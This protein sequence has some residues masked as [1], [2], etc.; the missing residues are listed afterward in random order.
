[1]MFAL[2]MLVVIT[3]AQ[4]IDKKSSVVNFKIKAMGMMNVEGTF[5][6]FS[7]DVKFDSKNLSSSSI[8]VCI[9]ASSVN[10][11]NTQRDNH[12]R[13][14]DFIDSEK[15][16][17]ICFTSSSIKADGNNYIAEGKLTLH[18]VTKT[19]KIP[20]TYQNNTLKGTL[21]VK[22]LD[23]KV[24]ESYGTFRAG[25]IIYLDINCVLNSQ[26]LTRL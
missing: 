21:E 17:K 13:S 4:T 25:E 26:N 15:Y 18:G 9:N 11:G 16:G 2:T 12:I 8:D 10:T 22:R 14:A 20:L 23:Y 6:G 3:N 5:T 24:G 7:G 1:M 19:V